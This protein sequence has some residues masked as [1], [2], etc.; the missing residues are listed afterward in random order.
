MKPVELIWPDIC[1]CLYTILF[2]F[3]NALG[4]NDPATQLEEV[5]EYQ[6][7]VDAVMKFVQANPGT[8]LV[9]TS[10]HETGGLTVGRQVTE[11]YPEYEWKPEALTKVKNSSEIL[12]W[13]WMQAISEGKDTREFLVEA[14]IKDGTGVQDPTD[15]EIDRLWAWKEKNTTYDFFASALADIVS[16]R[17]EIGV[18]YPSESVR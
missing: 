3:S 14:I 8:V 2:Q 6:H 13:Q 15:A 18:V 10:D 1:K 12:T 5:R 7:T 11:G 9:A 4:S 16:K 17:A